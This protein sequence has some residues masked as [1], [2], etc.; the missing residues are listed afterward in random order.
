MKAIEQINAF[1]IWQVCLQY[2]DDLIPFSTA[3]LAEIQTKCPDSELF[4]LGD[5]SY[6]SCC[7]DEVAAAHVE[8][9]SI[10]HFGHACLSKAVRLPVLYIFH[11]FQ[12]NTDHFSQQVENQL[13]NKEENII[14]FYDVGYFYKLGMI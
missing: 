7:V 14:V 4:I 1:G 5:T 10:I 9:D 2:P 13:T 6:G 11:T 3:I 8:S 12:I